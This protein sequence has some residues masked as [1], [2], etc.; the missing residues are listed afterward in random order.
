MNSLTPLNNIEI[1]QNLIFKSGKSQYALPILNIVEII[2]LPQLEI[3]PNNNPYVIGLLNFNNLLVN[4]IDVRIIFN[5]NIEPYDINHKIILAKTDET[6]FGII[7]DKIENISD[8][9][10]NEIQ[11]FSSLSNK[12]IDCTYTYNNNVIYL[13]NIFELENIVK[14]ETNKIQK[15]QTEFTQDKNS[16]DIFKNRALKLFERFNNIQIN[17]V[18]SENK[19]ITFLLEKTTFCIHIK[20]VKEF[21]KNFNITTLPCSPDY[22]EG[23][24]LLSGEFYTILNL[25]RFLNYANTSYSDK[26]KIIILNSENFKLG[27]HVDEIYEILNI[28]E[29]KIKN[30]ETQYDENKC[31]TNE[32]IDGNTVKPIL[33]INNLLRDKRLYID[34]K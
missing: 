34:E 32:Y 30:T 23:L 14:S 18:F 16:L 29:E 21:I 24:I 26:S 6:M 15:I 12:V 9:S 20:Y 1:Q 33:N 13:L 7:A 25:K 2:E 17:N 5:E 27:I 11:N 19:F 22:I 28:S 10:K 31:I 8:F 4:I 3:Q